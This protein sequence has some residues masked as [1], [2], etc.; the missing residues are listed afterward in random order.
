L[1]PLPCGGFSK[2]KREL[3]KAIEMVGGRSQ[4]EQMRCGGALAN[5]GK[6]KRVIPGGKKKEGTTSNSNR[7]GKHG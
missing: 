2:E 5:G 6:T 3:K 7:A 1:G 4:A